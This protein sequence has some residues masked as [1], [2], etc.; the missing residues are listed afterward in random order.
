MNSGASFTLYN[1]VYNDLR[2][3]ILSGVYKT[4]DKLPTVTQ[5]CSIY[6][7]SDATIRKSLEML[8]VSGYIHS[9]KRIGLFVSDKNR[10]AL[11]FNYSE[12]TSMR[13]KPDRSEVISVERLKNEVYTYFQ[14][15]F[16]LKIERIFYK[17]VLPVYLKINYL[18][19][20]T[21]RHEIN[22]PDRHWMEEM[23]YILDSHFIKKKLFIS[24]DSN[25]EHKSKLYIPQ[26][27]PMVKVLT[28]Y[29]TLEDRLECI[30][31][32]YCLASEI[33]MEFRQ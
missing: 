10:S 2:E 8:K 20:N 32:L 17:G 25:E 16:Y 29:Y 19:V 31:E 5:L 7:T 18:P 13:S 26:S 28:Y 22:K 30:S 3:K 4:G 15:K 27:M 11:V 24:V 33:N 12:A 9:V 14:D 23:D 6:S 1:S 21:R